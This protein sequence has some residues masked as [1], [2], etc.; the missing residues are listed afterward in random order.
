[1]TTQNKPKLYVLV[2]VPGSGKS[3]WVA[4]QDWASTAVHVGTDHWV[5]SEAAAR[6][7]TYSAIF[8]EYM[9]TAVRLMVDEVEICWEEH[10]DIIWDQTSTTVASRLKKTC[11]LPDYYKI[12]VVFKTPPMTELMRRLNSRPGK[13]IPRE[14]VAAMIKNWEDVSEDE[15]F[16]EIW[17]T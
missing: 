9:P 14:V 16:D 12:A 4:N 3:T 11:M 15:G 1:M 2:G 8:D 13:I 10:R 6:G 5:E 7:T 17:Y